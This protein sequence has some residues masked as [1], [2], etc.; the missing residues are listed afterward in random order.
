MRRKI[1]HHGGDDVGDHQIVRRLHGAFA[2]LHRVVFGIRD[3]RIIRV[4]HHV[5][6]QKNHQVGLVVGACAIPEKSANERDIAQ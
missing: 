6:P 5:R 2:P 4:P 1:R 3:T